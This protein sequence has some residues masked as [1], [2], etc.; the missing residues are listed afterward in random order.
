MGARQVVYFECLELVLLDGL[1]P[2][3]HRLPHATLFKRRFLRHKVGRARCGWIEDS[4]GREG[5]ISS[6]GRVKIKR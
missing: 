4:R 2:H 1:V 6:H 3:E 5:T